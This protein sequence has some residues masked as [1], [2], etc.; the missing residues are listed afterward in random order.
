MPNESEPPE[1]LYKY[2]SLATCQDRERVLRIITQGKIYYASPGQLNDPFDCKIPPIDA[3]APDL[4]RYWIEANDAKSDEERVSIYCKFNN[5]AP[6]L[7]KQLL[8]CEI[9]RFHEIIDPNVNKSGVFSLSALNNNTLM[10]SHYAD[11]HKGICL[12]FSSRI[13]RE[14]CR[15]IFPVCYRKERISG[16][17]DKK[18]YEDA[19]L[20]KEIVQ[21]KDCLWKYESEW[22]FLR[23]EFGEVDIPMDAVVGIVFGCL[24][25]DSDKFWLKH[26]IPKGRA[27]KRYEARIKTNEFG[28]E[29]VE[30]T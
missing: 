26:A 29:V 16:A 22:R 4:I 25:S 8:R 18:S 11:S 27:I 15:D 2:K 6:Y 17:I 9:D 23:P 3:F 12:K 5:P 21:L 10:W 20:F 19:K 1:F 13:L 14:S 24:T 30:I 28:L 7:C